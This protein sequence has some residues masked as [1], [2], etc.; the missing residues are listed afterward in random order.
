[1]L[2]AHIAGMK[3]ALNLTP[4]QEKS[5]APF[6][7]AVRAAPKARADERPA[8]REQVRDERPNPIQRMIMMS[9]RLGEASSDRRRRQAFV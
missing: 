2:D 3:A 9:D 5:W 6:E 8:K 4:D 7:S 1:M